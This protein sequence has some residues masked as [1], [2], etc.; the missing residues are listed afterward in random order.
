VAC[1]LSGFIPEK[2]FF[3][4]AC[5]PADQLFPGCISTISGLDCVIFLGVNVLYCV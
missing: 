4:P 2:A 1:V 3:H 5:T